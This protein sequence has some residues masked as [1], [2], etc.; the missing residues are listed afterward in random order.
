M[1]IVE[2]SPLCIC[3]NAVLGQKA[4]GW[5]KT[6][7]VSVVMEEAAEKGHETAPNLI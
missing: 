7:M 6:Y 5:S 1:D 2:S 4:A 3:A